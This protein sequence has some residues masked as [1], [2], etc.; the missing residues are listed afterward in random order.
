MHLR[1]QAR[2]DESNCLFRAAAYGDG[3]TFWSTQTRLS[4]ARQRCEGLA[5]AHTAVSH[6]QEVAQYADPLGRHL[7][8]ACSETHGGVSS[9]RV[10]K[11]PGNTATAQR[12]RGQAAAQI[13]DAFARHFAP[14]RIDASIQITKQPSLCTIKQRRSVPLPPAV[15]TA[16][17]RRPRP[18]SLAAARWPP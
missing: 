3:N 9:D 16:G 15:G 8:S 11:T 17:C 5:C 1:T 10:R 12:R 2:N 4:A 7:G 6:R 18:S 14:A 13:A